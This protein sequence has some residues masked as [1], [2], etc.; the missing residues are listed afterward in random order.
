METEDQPQAPRSPAQFPEDCRRLFAG[1]TIELADLAKAF[2]SSDGLWLPVQAVKIGEV[3]QIAD[4]FRYA[5][6]KTGT[7]P[8]LSLLKQYAALFHIDFCHG[9]MDVE[10]LVTRKYTARRCYSCGVHGEIDWE[11][12]EYRREEGEEVLPPFPR[13][14]DHAMEC[15]AVHIEEKL[16][17]LDDA[18]GGY[19]HATSEEVQEMA[20]K[21]IHSIG[22]CDHSHQDEEEE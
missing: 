14:Y 9:G 22:I 16:S 15:P 20:D 6:K 18:F 12:V 21:L 19:L 2:G 3:V 8:P 17:D 1:E 13:V 7:R 10:A 11:H 5:R 4:N